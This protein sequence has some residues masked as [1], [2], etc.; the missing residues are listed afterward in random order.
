VIQTVVYGFTIGAILY[1]FSVGLSLTFGTMH[2]INFA[3]GMVY[4]LGVYL[5]ITLLQALGNSFLLALAVSLAAML[6]VAYLIERVVIRRLYGESL[7]Y[8]IIATYGV[9]LIG[10]DAIKLIWG[11]TPYPVSDPIGL[12]L[13]LVGMDLPVYRLLIVV[14]AVALFLALRVFFKRSIIGRIVTAALEDS[15]GVRCL[16][17]DVNRY[18]SIIFVLGSTLAVLGGILYAPVSTAEPYMGFHILLLAFAVVIV[19]GMGNLNGTF[20][21]AMVLGMVMAV[22]G[23]FWSQ[24]AT[25]MVFVVMALVIIFR[26]R[27]CN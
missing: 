19:G 26:P 3:H 23:R 1:F 2:I 4:A 16:G 20:V 9:L 10:T 5:F 25:A 12:S 14:S 27:E 7:D 18:F 15:D 13:P 8:A 17:L 22:T 21:A 11:T 6:P 24:A